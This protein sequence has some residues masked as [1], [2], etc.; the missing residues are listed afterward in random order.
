MKTDDLISLLATGVAPVDRHTVM[1]RFA[2][3]ILVGIVGATLLMSSVLGVRHD[4]A[5]VAT[6]PIFWAKVALPLSLMIG[7]LWMSTRL[8][9]P[10]VAVGGSRWAIA[11]PVAAVWLAAAWVLMSAPD[12]ARLAIVLG[13]TWRICPFAIAM[14]STPGFIAVFWA[15]KGMAPTRLALTGAAGGLLAGSTATLAYCLHCPEMGIPFWGA[16][17]LL[18]MLVPTVVGA[19][20]GPR[21]LRW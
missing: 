2:L 20:L 21:L 1:K 12:N 3:A 16:W 13:K 17:Y 6:T 14:L 9:R 19:L 15:L 11:A 7:S 10:G 8:A 5:E 4:L 18:G